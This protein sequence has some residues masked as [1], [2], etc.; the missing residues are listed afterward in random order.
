[1][2]IHVCLLDLRVTFVTALIS[3]R[4]DIPNEVAIPIF[5]GYGTVV[6]QFDADVAQALTQV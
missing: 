4:G 3:F 2:N 1:M 6:C 5:L